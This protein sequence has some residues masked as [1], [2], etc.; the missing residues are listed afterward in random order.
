ML[1]EI[2]FKLFKE[3]FY[4]IRL[5]QGFAKQPDGLGIGNAL[6]QIQPQEPHEGQPVTDLRFGVII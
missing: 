3:G 5:S 6:I 4:D 1:D 2:G